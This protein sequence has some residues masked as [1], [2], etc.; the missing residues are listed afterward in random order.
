MKSD[1][2]IGIYRNRKGIS[3]QQ[4]ADLLK[5]PRTTVSFYETKRQYP[6]L[7]TAEKI[8]EILEVTIGQLYNPEELKVILL[9]NNQKINVWLR[10]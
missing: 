8:A 4:L 1:N 6:D 7:K 2:T 3:Q 9:R 5:I 10:K